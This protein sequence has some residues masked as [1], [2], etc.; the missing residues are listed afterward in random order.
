MDLLKQR[1]GEGEEK[2]AAR[3]NM[4]C[5]TIA[6]LDESKPLI[7]NQAGRIARA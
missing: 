3:K 7:W 5:K 4:C 2:K 6:K 1:G